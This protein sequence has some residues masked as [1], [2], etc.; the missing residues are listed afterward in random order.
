MQ[1]KSWCVTLTDPDPSD[2]MTTAVLWPE[3]G[4]VWAIFEAAKK[5]GFRVS[6]R[7][8]YFAPSPRRARLPTLPD[9]EESAPQRPKNRRF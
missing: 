3:P 9:A 8:V 5:L 1:K 7:L 4:E 6:A 2:H